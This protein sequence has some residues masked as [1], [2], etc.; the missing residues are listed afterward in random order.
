MADQKFIQVGNKVLNVAHIASMEVLS[1]G[2]TVML[3]MTGGFHPEFM[4]ADAE[5]LMAFFAPRAAPDQRDPQ[6]ANEEEPN[7]QP[8]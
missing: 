3:H 2:K 6:P 8:A 5:A 4:G 1:D 7:E